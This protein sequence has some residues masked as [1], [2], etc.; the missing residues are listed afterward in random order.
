MLLI[1][2]LNLL[3]YYYSFNSS[4]FLVQECYNALLENYLRI[5]KI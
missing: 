1:T 4:Y 3:H 5:F 2:N